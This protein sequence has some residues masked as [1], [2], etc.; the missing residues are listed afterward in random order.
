MI[1]YENDCVECGKDCL[2]G[3]PYQNVA[4][5]YCDECKED[6]ETLYNY[7]GEELCEDCLLNRFEKVRV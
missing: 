1:K 7:D 2:S 4:Y 5:F 3:C 6:V